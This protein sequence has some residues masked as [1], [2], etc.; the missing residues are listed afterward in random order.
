MAAKD[1]ALAWRDALEPLI[2]KLIIA[3]DRMEA[4]AD[5]FEDG[6]ITGTVAK[7]IA[8]Q[9]IVEVNEAANGIASI[10]IPP[11]AQ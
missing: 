5:M 11:F 1:D 6:I 10:P 9:M 4:A 7:N 3:R 8:T 2:H